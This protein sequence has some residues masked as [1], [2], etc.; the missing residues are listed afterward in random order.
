MTY[1][2][3]VAELCAWGPPLPTLSK[4][5][6]F[7]ILFLFATSPIFGVMLQVQLSACLLFLSPL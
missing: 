5:A 6:A 3:T 1:P 7:R 2:P 4:M